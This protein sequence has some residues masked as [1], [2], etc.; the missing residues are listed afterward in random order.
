MKIKKHKGIISHYLSPEEWQA[1]MDASRARVEREAFARYKFM[2]WSMYS[3]DK[4]AWENLT[5]PEREGWRH[6]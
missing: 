2:D 6:V 4:R 3:G 1:A 5:E